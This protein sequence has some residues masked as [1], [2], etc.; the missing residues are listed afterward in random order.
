MVS[1]GLSKARP[2][3]Q[4]SF[5]SKVEKEQLEYEDK[6]PEDLPTLEEVKKKYGVVVW[7]KFTA[8]INN[9]EVAG[10]QRTSGTLV[11]RRGYTPL[12]EQEAIW[13]GICTRNEIAIKYDEIRTAGGRKVKVPSCFVAATNKTGHID[14][15]KFLKS[16]G[17]PLGGNIDSQHVSNAGYG[18]LDSSSIY[19]ERR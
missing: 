7:C 2:E 8:C 12:N 5:S 19:E 13:P 10:L 16:D 9:E 1:G 14:F 4:I 3:I 15:S 11:K 18:A 17:S 6:F